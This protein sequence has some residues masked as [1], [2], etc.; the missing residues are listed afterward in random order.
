MDG[1]ISLIS[2]AISCSSW[3]GPK[4]D[5]FN[6]LIEENN[7]AQRQL[8]QSLHSELKTNRK[9]PKDKRDNKAFREMGDEVL[10]QR[11][12]E[13]VPVESSKLSTRK[14]HV[15][16]NK[17]LQKKSDKRISAEMKELKSNSQ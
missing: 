9:D 8:E 13:Q 11:T 4:S 6:S 1:C 5:D 15:A 2:L 17:E 16:I 7:A 10:G 14:S 12:T 3:A